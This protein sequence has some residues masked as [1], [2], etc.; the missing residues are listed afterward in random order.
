MNAAL[1]ARQS[2]RNGMIEGCQTSVLAFLMSESGACD[3]LLHQISPTIFLPP[4]SKIVEAI[5]DLY[6]ER[7]KINLITVSNRLSEKRALAEC[8]G[9]AGITAI[10]TGTTSQE[11]AESA[12]EYIIENYLE[13]M[14]GEV[15]KQ[16]H[17]GQLTIEQAQERLVQISS[18]KP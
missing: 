5:F 7:E 9:R 11:I 14:A 6:D 17:R 4:H 8:G 16:L 1:Q 2:A 12:L 15:G 10:A 13:R 18:K 3:K